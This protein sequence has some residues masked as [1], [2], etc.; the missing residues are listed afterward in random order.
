MLKL[1]MLYRNI[2]HGKNIF[3]KSKE[4]IVNFLILC[5]IENFNI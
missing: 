2:T 1:N 3:I 5:V 4:I